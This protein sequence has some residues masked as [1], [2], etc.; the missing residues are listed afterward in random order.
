MFG[1]IARPIGVVQ[2]SYSSKIVLFFVGNAALDPGGLGAYSMYGSRSVWIF[3]LIASSSASQSAWIEPAK[4]GGGDGT[5]T[6]S[7]IRIEYVAERGST[8]TDGWVS[9]QAQPIQCRKWAN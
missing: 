7:E 4:K 6:I 3:Y 2:T 9:E 8:L 5:S 1:V